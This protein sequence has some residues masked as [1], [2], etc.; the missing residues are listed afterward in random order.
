MAGQSRKWLIFVATT[1]IQAFTGT[2]FDF[3]SYSSDLK[4]VLEI[5]QVQLNYL[6]VAS[7]MGKAFG[8]CSGVSLMYLPL[9]VVMFMAATMGLFGYGLQWLVI[10]R[11]IT[12]PYFLVFL[13]SL[14]AGCGICWFNTV[15]YVLCIRNFPVNRSLALSLTISFNGLTA[16]L[17]T[18]IA[19]AINPNDD[20]IYLFLNALVPLFTSG[21][22]LVPILCQPP[23]QSL[24][25]EAIRRDSF[26]F[27][28]LNIL[29]VITGL[30]LL[31]LNSLSSNVSMARILFGGALGLLVLPCVCP[32]L[33]VHVS[34]HVGT[35]TLPFVLITQASI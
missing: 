14:M 31:L 25:T 16:A 24:T 32:E 33:C 34:G 12:L 23:L 27:L 7:D 4:T 35:S 30:Y 19:N 1:W 18:L 8:W 3:S 26:I 17:Y 22:A 13:L 11:I 15:C 20:T 29:A 21:I 28:C 5:T 10:Q 9:W 6:S 2:N